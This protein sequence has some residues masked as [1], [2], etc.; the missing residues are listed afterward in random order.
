MA[1][2]SGSSRILACILVGLGAF[3]IVAALLLPTYT[4][5]ALAKTPLDL[6]ITTVA[7]TGPDGG[8]VLDA[9]T[10]TAPTGKAEVNKKVPLVSQRYFTVED[11][12][13]SSKMTVQA[14]STLRRTDKQG[15]TGLLTASVDRVT[16]DR[17]SGM[18]VDDPIGSIQ[19]QSDKPAEEVSHTGLQYRFPFDTE[20]KSYPYFDINVRESFDI[21]FVEETEINGTKVYHFNQKIPAIDLSKVVNSPTNKLS[22]PADK[23]G[24]AGGQAPVTMTRW[25]TN[26][27]DIWI[28]PKT[29]TVI[30]GGEK[31]F[32]YYARSADKPE[33][34]V[35]RGDLSYD[36]NTIEA[37][38]K[39]AKEGTDKLSLY[40]RTVP[41]IL[42]I[43]GVL[44]LI[45]GLVLGLRG[46][47]DTAGPAVTRRP[48]GPG[49]GA[50][51]PAPAPGA[52]DWTTDRTEEIPVSRPNLEK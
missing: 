4:L 40:G 26:E 23:W 6:E 32:Q 7:V 19:V 36:E 14:G 27:R 49:P 33:V 17:K 43:L 18:P 3:F 25:Y 22:L 52:N 46:G 16:I 38:I 10:L 28:E 35:L 9:K 34:T 1:E 37:Q 5:N 42:G 50:A 2:R 44:S 47:S 20:K 51:N 31:P 15:D 41:I 48:A 12:A 11:P 21:N 8:E 24:V 39:K 45:A 29:G 30:K 13:D